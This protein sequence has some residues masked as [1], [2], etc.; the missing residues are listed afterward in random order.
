MR[1]RVIRRRHLVR[2]TANHGPVPHND[3]TKRTA[4]AFLDPPPGQGDG[5][6]KKNL[7]CCC[8]HRAKLWGLGIPGQIEEIL[9]RLRKKLHK[10]P[11]SPVKTPFFPAETRLDYLLH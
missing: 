1:R 7:I 4:L 2:A 6:L 8:D 11:H 9:G 5:L 3:A 10:I